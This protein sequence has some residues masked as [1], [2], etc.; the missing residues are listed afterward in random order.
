MVQV[1]ATVA[2]TAVAAALDAPKVVDL[3]GATV[4]GD[5]AEGAPTGAAAAGGQQAPMMWN[6]NTSGFVLR[7]MA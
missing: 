1:Y 5:A 7:R 2:Q 6:N 4:E 3:V